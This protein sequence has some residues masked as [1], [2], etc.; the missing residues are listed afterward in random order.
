MSKI[1]SSLPMDLQANQG[2]AI[3]V[4]VV[5]DIQAAQARRNTVKEVEN[6]VLLR[7]IINTRLAVIDSREN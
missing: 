5:N 4:Q 2:S 1:D 3:M 6:L 7:R